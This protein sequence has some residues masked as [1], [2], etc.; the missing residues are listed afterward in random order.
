MNDI[1]ELKEKLKNYRLL[2]ILFGLMFLLHLANDHY[3][4][5]LIWIK[6]VLGISILVLFFYIIAFNLKNLLD[7]NRKKIKI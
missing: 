6:V 7:N 2:F 1:N 4:N 5:T 3:L